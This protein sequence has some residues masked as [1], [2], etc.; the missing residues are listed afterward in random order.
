MCGDDKT[1]KSNLDSRST[2]VEVITI[3]LQPV[4]PLFPFF[5]MDSTPA[6]HPNHQKLIDRAREFFAEV[7]DL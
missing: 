1:Y 3:I 2:P 4:R 5:K 6:I 7:E